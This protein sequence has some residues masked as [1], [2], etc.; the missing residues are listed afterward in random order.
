MIQQ[1]HVFNYFCIYDMTIDLSWSGTKAPAHYEDYEKL[2]FVQ[3]GND[4]KKLRNNRIVPVLSLYGANSSGK[5]TVLKAVKEL[6]KIV[7][8]GINYDNFQPNKIKQTSKDKQYTEF[9][10]V[11]WKQGDKY[12][13]LLRY[14]NER[15]LKEELKKNDKEIFLVDNNRIC[16]VSDAHIEIGDL[17][18]E[19]KTRC[20]NIS[21][22]CQIKTFLSG[23]VKAFPGA[24]LSINRA[25]EYILN[26]IQFLPDN[27]I[28]FSDAVSKLASIYGNE[29][30]EDEREDRAVQ[31]IV[32][33][34]GKL[35][36]GIVGIE[37]Y[38]EQG[39]LSNLHTVLDA[40][41]PNIEQIRIDGGVYRTDFVFTVHK[42][43]DGKDVRFKLRNESKGTRLLMGLLGFLLYSIK[44]GQTILIDELDES[45]HSLLLIQLVRLFKEKRLNK[46]AQLIFTA[47]NTDLLA[48]GLLSVYEIGFIKYEKKRGTTFSSSADNHDAKSS[49]DIRRLY[50]DG[51]FGGVPFPYV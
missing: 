21:N 51:Y 42:S 31:E 22:N 45:M 47:H 34:L 14:D 8:E 5:T 25:H 40:L 15:I 2:L 36:L 28:M 7:S 19:Y 16:D 33:Y 4:K 26:D 38:K 43:E 18:K 32:K 29:L 9:E 49:D 23:I 20:I 35:D 48:S 24:S 44:K 39:P 6:T 3:Q 50:L 12:D 17:E 11:F 46:N 41:E 10:I 1:I 30:T 13:Y 27:K 37:V